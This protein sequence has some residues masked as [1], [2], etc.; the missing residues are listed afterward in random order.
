MKT[1]TKNLTRRTTLALLGIGAGVFVVV[2]LVAGLVAPLKHMWM[3]TAA[4]VLG[5][6]MAAIGLL[7][8]G[9]FFRKP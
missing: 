3:R 5:S 2:T 7:L 4:R 9:W 6:W 8:I 1:A